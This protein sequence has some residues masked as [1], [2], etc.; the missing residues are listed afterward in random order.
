M[1]A[2]GALLLVWQSHLTFLIDDWD[3]LLARRGFNAHA[4]LDPHARHLIIGPALV[5]KAIQASMGMDSIL[6][7]AVAAIGSFLASVLL[8]FIYLSRRVGDWIALA[9]VLPVLVMGTAYQDLLSPFQICD[10]A[11]IA[12]GIG[13]LLAIE[14]AN[15][16]GDLIACALL[17]AS[18]AFAEIALAFAAGVLVAIV[19]QRGPLRR[20]WIIVVPVVL[21]AIWYVSFGSPVSKDPSALSAHNLATS[22]VYVLDGLA[23]SI[24]SLFGLGAPLE[25]SGTAGA[26]GWGRPLLVALVVASIWVLRR[27]T[28]MRRWILVVLAVGITFW[29]M[30]AGNLAG[31]APTV[32]RYQYVGAVFVL[33][34]AG[35]IAALAGG[36]GGERSWRHLRWRARLARQPRDPAQRLSQLDGRLGDRAGRARRAG[37]RRRPCE[38]QPRPHPR[39]LRLLLLQPGHGGPVPLRVGE[40]RL[41]RLFAE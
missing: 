1:A 16:R 32:S 13:A 39:E 21:Y 10:S 26:L 31:R 9:A 19:L 29:F 6:P 2:S 5:F 37:G 3:L 8:L 7:Y 30:T 38:P 12:F 22:P 18:L 33:L 27:R 35:E 11:S 17:I 34:I 36:Q 25:L 23:S 4:L 20:V 40:V 14:G 41:P 15:R 24:A 28:P